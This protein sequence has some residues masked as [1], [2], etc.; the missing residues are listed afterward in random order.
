MKY[1]WLS[2]L[3]ILA[4]AVAAGVFTYQRAQ[5][6]VRDKDDALAWLRVEFQLT[7][8]QTQRIEA[9]HA[10]YQI[11]CEGHCAEV[12]DSH[13]H[14][15]DARAQNRPPSEIAA[16]QTQI[17]AVDAECKASTAAHIQQ[18]AAVI[19]GAQ[20]QRYLAIVLPRLATLD[21]A[22][23]GTLDLGANANA[24]ASAQTPPAHAQHAGH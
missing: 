9:L 8:A 19:G 22:G 7:A 14:L 24:D 2:G 5:Q 20:G 23:P 16:A 6:R 21:H 18:I 12:R 15:A 13:E 4:V 17:A 10:A 11:V 1:R 3:A